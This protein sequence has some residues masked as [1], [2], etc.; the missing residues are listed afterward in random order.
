MNRPNYLAFL[1]LLVGAPLSA[2][3]GDWPYCRGDLHAT[4]TVSEDLPK[5]LKLLWKKTIEDGGFEGVAVVEQGVVYAGDN[6]GTVYALNLADGSTRWEQECEDSGF[7][8]GGIVHGEQ[9]T[10]GDYNG[11]IRSLDKATGNELWKFEMQGESYAAPY[12]DANRILVTSEA[13]ELVSLDPTT[14]EKQWEFQIEAPLR[15]WPTVV[16]GKVMLAGCD[17][18]LHAVEVESGKEVALTDIDGPT[19]ST[20]AVYDGKVLFGTEQGSFYA[21]EASSMEVAWH[22]IDPS[23]A[24]SVRTAAAV[25]SQAIVY[26]TQGKTFFAL[27]PDN[28]NKNWTFQ[29]SKQGREF[30]R[31]RG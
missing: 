14:G 17:E 24:R 12:A 2:L 8:A 15:C 25:S 7:I 9:F 11:I 18:R 23:Y 5:E 28:G 26:G 1:V 20:P 10:I 6:N 4:A 22:H 21:I 13:G 31:D 27:S 29:N 16:D 19:G 30:P 3:A